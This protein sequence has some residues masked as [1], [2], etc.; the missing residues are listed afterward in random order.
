M[1]RTYVPLLFNFYRGEI[2]LQKSEISEDTYV[3]LKLPALVTII[4]TLVTL[5]FS[6]A[7]FYFGLKIS[8]DS[9]ENEIQKRVTIYD[10][11]QDRKL[12][13]IS[14]AMYRREMQQKMN[15]VLNKL[16]IL[17]DSK[18]KEHFTDEN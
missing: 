17:T 4:G 8:V 5:T 12:D 10:Y 13:S 1:Y 11:K 9:N 18:Y 15:T 2:K 6:V 7:F 16:E 3:K 14:N